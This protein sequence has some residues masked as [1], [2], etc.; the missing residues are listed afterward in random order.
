MLHVK[1]ATPDL[2]SLSQVFYLGYLI[3]TVIMIDN[4]VWRIYDPKTRFVCAVH[5]V[6]V[7]AGMKMSSCPV[8]SVKS[9]NLFKD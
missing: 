1:R 6:R 5:Y 4:H 2:I 3:S 7:F 8:S 9:T